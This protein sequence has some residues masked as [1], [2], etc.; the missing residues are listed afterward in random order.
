MDKNQEEIATTKCAGNNSYT[1]INPSNFTPP[2]PPPGMCIPDCASSETISA[3]SVRVNCETAIKEHRDDDIAE[4]CSDMTNV[5]ASVVDEVDSALTI[6][7]QETIGTKYD[8]G[9]VLE[10]STNISKNMNEATETRMPEYMNLVINMGH[11]TT[12][13][14]GAIP[15][16]LPAPPV[17]PRGI[18]YV[19]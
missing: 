3:D 8:E 7:G 13:V 12:K 16:K 2:V 17:P 19:I 14:L 10:D 18:T 1:N 5:R 4:A 11:E 15:K 6:R 9:H